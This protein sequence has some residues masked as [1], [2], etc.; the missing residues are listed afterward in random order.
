M[1]TLVKIT[2]GVLILALFKLPY[3]LYIAINFYVACMFG[4]ACY[5][6]FQT[7]HRKVAY[8]CLTATILYQPLLR[9][10]LG[11]IGWMTADAVA[12]IVLLIFIAGDRLLNYFPKFKADVDTI[13]EALSI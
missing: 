10:P 7:Q 11:R 2:I 12:A 4:Y 6:L 1:K 5:M 9:I 13:R 3:P 8:L